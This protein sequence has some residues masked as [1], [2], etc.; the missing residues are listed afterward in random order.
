MANDLGHQDHEVASSGVM[1]A[2][3][4]SSVGMCYA[5]KVIQKIHQNLGPLI[6]TSDGKSGQPIARLGGGMPRSG[7][8]AHL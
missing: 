7:P 4:D 3:K 2:R 8:V 6:V 1:R 5:K